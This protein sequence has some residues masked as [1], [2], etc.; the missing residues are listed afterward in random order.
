DFPAF[1]KQLR[2]AGV[3]SPVLGS[4]GIDTPT[5]AGLGDVVDGVIHSSAGLPSPGTPLEAFAKKFTE[6]TGKPFDTV[7]IANGYEIGLI[8][9]AAVK[10]AGS[11]DPQ[12]LRDAVAN[13]K[14]V[15]GV[16]GK[17]TYAGTDRMPSRDIALVELKGGTRSLVKTATPNPA[18]VPAP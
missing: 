2:A 3:T 6:K 1:I 15:Q 16:T 10:A 13:L 5:I 9:D 4:D 18:D 17:I 11:L 7:Y 12:A 14:D 8:I